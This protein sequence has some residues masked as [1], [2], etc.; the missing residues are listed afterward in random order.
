MYYMH[1]KAIAEGQG[2]I[3]FKENRDGQVVGF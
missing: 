1:E 2:T 3:N